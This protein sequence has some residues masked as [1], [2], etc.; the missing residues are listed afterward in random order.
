M[1]RFRWHFL[2]LACL[3]ILYGDGARVG[4]PQVSPVPVRPQV[5]AESVINADE[6]KPQQ[7]PPEWA[8]KFPPELEHWI[9]QSEPFVQGISEA[10]QLRRRLLSAAP[11]GG[12]YTVRISRAVAAFQLHMAQSGTAHESIGR[13]NVNQD[14]LERQLRTAPSSTHAMSSAPSTVNGLG[15]GMCGP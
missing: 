12:P 6:P 9:T 10:D 13:F 4:W 8:A 5:H 2:G 3:V 15:S 1:M 7:V 11:E 14:R